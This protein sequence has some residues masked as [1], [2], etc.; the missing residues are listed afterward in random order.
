MNSQNHT[1]ARTYDLTKKFG[2]I[3]AVKDLNIEIAHGEVFGFLGPNGAGKTTTIGLLLGLLS[4][5]SGK[6]EV[7]GEDISVNA[8]V[9]K[10]VGSIVET[11]AFYPY[12]SGADNLRVLAT[13]GGVNEQR[14]QSVLNIVGMADRAKHKYKTYSLGMKQRLGI[15][16]ALL[17]DPELILLDEPTNGLDPAGMKEV[18]ELIV[19][20]SGMGKTIFLSSH[21]LGE[22]E[23]VCTRVA[24]IKR[25]EV[26]AHGN[27]NE[28]LQRGQRLQVIVSDTERAVEIL[29]HVDWIHNVTARNNMIFLETSKENASRINEFLAK[30]NIFLSE[31][32]TV[33]STLEDFFLEITQGGNN[34]EAR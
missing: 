6:V 22:V 4:P 16:A 5:T 15:A 24:I 29:K 12:L 33:D 10:R 21:L 1:V 9:L 7:F 14:I 28:L 3:T 18:R 27:V 19:Q 32:K 2:S 25:G 23:Q 34:V 11:S 26:I 30:S 31:L 20:L 8:A 17:S 13:I